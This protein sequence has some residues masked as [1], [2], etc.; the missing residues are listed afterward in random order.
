MFKWVRYNRNYLIHK[1][2]EQG[3]LILYNTAKKCGVVPRKVYELNNLFEETPPEKSLEL[4]ICWL[5][6][7]IKKTFDNS[8]IMEKL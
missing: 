1:E 7:F 5:I 3:E 6:T 8:S 4:F 2:I